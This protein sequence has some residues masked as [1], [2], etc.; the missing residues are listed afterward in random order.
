MEKI[1]VVS[2]KVRRRITGAYKTISS[3]EALVYGNKDT[4][5]SLY[6]IV[7]SELCSYRTKESY[8]AKCVLFEAK[9]L[10]TGFIS[11]D[12]NHG[13]ILRENHIRWEE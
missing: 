9:I 6:N 10:D 3:Y 12:E 4:A 11:T 2:M 8:R 13:K 7:F 5:M 1:Y